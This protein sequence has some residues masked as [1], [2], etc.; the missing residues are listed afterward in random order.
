MDGIVILAIA[1]EG[2]VGG[3]GTENQSPLVSEVTE[4]LLVPYVNYLT[5]GIDIA[6]GLIIGL[7]AIFALISFFKILIKPIK[8]QTQSKETIRLSLTRGM[9]LALDFEIGSDILKTILLPSVRELTILAVIVGI[10]IVLS[11]SLSKEIERQST[12]I[13]KN[14]RMENTSSTKQNT[15]FQIWKLLPNLIV[16]NNN[17]YNY[18]YQFL[19]IFLVLLLLLP[20]INIEDIIFTITLVIDIIAI[21]VIAVSV[22]QTIY[23]LS[24]Y[25]FKSI[26]SSA[27]TTSISNSNIIQRN[28]ITGLILALEFEAA[29]TILKMGVFT[30]LVI[31]K[32]SSSTLSDNFINNFIIFI[33][34]ISIRI[35]IKQS[36]GRFDKRNSIWECIQTY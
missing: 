24:I 25:N 20:Y 10:R 7:S 31:D 14:K 35:A 11:W 36:L 4:S 19:S 32:S 29:N 18:L 17:D 30:S 27:K 1:Q 23:Y 6:A 12:V 3:T 33:M 9:L 28:F 34:V 26:L 8:E 2:I 13:E 5:F 16:I 15:W 22:I 21:S